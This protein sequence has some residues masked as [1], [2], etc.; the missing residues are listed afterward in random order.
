MID[1]FYYAASAVMVVGVIV[2]MVRI[3]FPPASPELCFVD[4]PVPAGGPSELQKVVG[5]SGYQNQVKAPDSSCES[6]M[7]WINSGK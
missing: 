4:R 3:V 2:L 5:P 7:R 1:R 6:G